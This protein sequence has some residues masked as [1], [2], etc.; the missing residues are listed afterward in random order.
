[1]VQ[2]AT[3]TFGIILGTA[4]QQVI[5][6]PIEPLSPRPSGIPPFFFIQPCTDQVHGVG[7]SI[8][9]IRSDSELDPNLGQDPET[10]STLADEL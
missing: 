8:G 10:F 2:S 7:G 9:G 1:M 3:F 5:L 4:M 6:T